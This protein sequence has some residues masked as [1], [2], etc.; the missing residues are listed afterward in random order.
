MT[1]LRNAARFVALCLLDALIIAILFGI[2]IAV[3][4]AADARV[5]NLNF[6]ALLA[7]AVPTATLIRAIQ[8]RRW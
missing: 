5:P 4:H 8:E 1:D 2:G 3:A 7:L 6:G